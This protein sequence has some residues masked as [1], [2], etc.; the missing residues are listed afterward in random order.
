MILDFGLK[1]E[2]E[3]STE[4]GLSLNLKDGET[5]SLQSRHGS[6]VREIRLVRGLRPGLVS[7]PIG[8]N[9]NDALKLIALTPL[10]GSHSS[11]LKTCQIRLEKL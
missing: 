2:V 6:I 4:E 9:G 3:I 10:E 11:G 1:G 5:V 7:V 8:F